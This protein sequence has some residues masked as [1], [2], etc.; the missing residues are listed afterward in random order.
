MLFDSLPR[1]SVRVAP[2]V[3]HVPGWVGVD[4]QKALVEEMRGI[5]REYAATPMAMV[6]PR[7]KSGG[8][9]SVFQLHLGRYWH[10]P[11]YRYV[12]N[13][14]GTRVPPVPESL[15]RIA[16]GALRAA[17]EVAP[18]LEPWVENFVPEMALV[19]YYP[20]GS[21]M[22]MHVDDSEESP[23]PVISLSIGDEA[24]FRM[25]H[26]EARTRPWDDITL[27]SGDLV[28]FGG[29]KRFAYHGVVRVNDGTLPEGCGLR[30]GR[31]N[32]TIRQVSARAVS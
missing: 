6:R 14:D 21:A 11:S 15:R 5:A 23:A 25:G 10:Y 8:Q 19:N 9:M 1:P 32:I 28:V 12:D 13:M 20:P 30:E 29:P 26:T 27:C 16:P 22:G 18:E 7:L 4:K 31:I 2:G 3:G 24:L 17:A